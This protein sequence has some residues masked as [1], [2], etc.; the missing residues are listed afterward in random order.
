MRYLTFLI[1]HHDRLHHIVR[2]EYTLHA[3]KEI[4]ETGDPVLFRAFFLLI[5]NIVLGTWRRPDTGDL[6]IR[7]FSLKDTCL[8]IN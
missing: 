1:A 2:G 5:N 6:A 4:L 8:S 3:M 7:L